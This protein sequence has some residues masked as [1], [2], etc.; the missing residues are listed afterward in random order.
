[1]LRL[2]QV[3]HPLVRND[4]LVATAPRAPRSQ[5]DYVEPPPPSES[6]KVRALAGQIVEKADAELAAEAASNQAFAAL[7][8]ARTLMGRLGLAASALDDDEPE[9]QGLPTVVEVDAGQDVDA[10]AEELR[11]LT[12]D[13]SVARDR[14]A[15]MVTEMSQT[16]SEPATATVPTLVIR[17]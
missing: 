16:L 14:F 10:E 7:Q 2:L 11:A 3:W 15:G 13:A 12:D 4:S 5:D 9:A 6:E 1:M 17:N 8:A